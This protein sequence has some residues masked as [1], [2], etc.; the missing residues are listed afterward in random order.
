MDVDP[1]L[2]YMQ[3]IAKILIVD[4]KRENLVAIKSILKKANAELVTALS[5]QEALKSLISNEYALILL[6]V[7]MPVMN[8]YELAE[9]LR[10]EPS[11]KE[12][13][14]IF[15]SAVD[16]DELF[17]LKAYSSGAVDFIYK[18]INREIL[19]S[20]V[21]V[22]LELYYQKETLRELK[23]E[24]EKNCELKA[25]FLANMSHEI[26][27]PM[28][29]VLGFTE[30]LQ[31]TSLDDEQKLHVTHIQKSGKLLL[32]IINDILDIS[33]IESGNMTMEQF[34]VNIDSINENAIAIAKASKECDNL[35]F[36]YNNKECSHFHLLGDEN[37]LTQILINLLNNSIKFTPNGKITLTVKSEELQDGKV[38][39]SYS[40]EDTGI[41]IPKSKLKSIFQ[42]FTQA[43]VSTTRKFGGTGL[44]LS[45]AKSFV[46][47]MGGE[48]SVDSIVGEWTCFSFHIILDINKE[49][50]KE[51]KAAK[52]KNS[53]SYSGKKVL[54]VE[55][56]KTNQ[57]L[58]NMI[59]KKYKFEIN[60]ADDGEK[61]LDYL[62]DHSVDIIFMDIQM[63]NMDG[64]ECT[65]QLRKSITET[66][67]IALTADVVAE[68]KARAY[69]AGMNYFLTK[70]INRMELD[71]TLKAAI[72]GPF[73]R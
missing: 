70:P 28:N 39:L 44:G 58:L 31:E 13:P 3:N 41:G 48:I 25:A 16:K 40:V 67:V 33:K 35:N 24:A 30:L 21:N 56:N 8:G 45:I 19:I 9:I 18:P 69:E 62:K 10:E 1:G 27:T 26:R 42:N 32:S 11:T 14:I 12:T 53:E 60:I 55:D 38:K 52:N 47:M 49:A 22:F 20:K 6:D 73:A 63:P 23:M 46:N 59:L 7:N 51:L 61:A 17:E 36:E 66:P 37:R 2:K 4:D 50:P 64:I 29:S 57:R 54:V 15:V 68:E 72:G 71:K 5:A 65:R 34:P 43:D